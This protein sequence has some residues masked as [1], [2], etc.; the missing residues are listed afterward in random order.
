GEEL[1]SPRNVRFDAE[2]AHHLLRW[3][4]AHSA[5]GDVRYEVELKVYGTN[6]SWTPIPNCMKIWGHSCDLTFYTLAPALR[7][8]AR[9]RAVSGNHMSPWKKTSSFSP[10]EASLRLSGQSLSV[11]GNTIHVQLQLLLRAGNLTVR[12]DDVQ[13]HARRYRVY[14]RRMPDNWTFQVMETATE[15]NISN[16]FWATEYC[17]SVE[18]DVASRHIRSTRTAEQCVAT[19][20]R[21]RSAELVLNIISSFFITLVILGLLGALLVCAYVKQPMR[22]PSVL[23]SFIK[24]SSLWVEHESPSSGSPDTDPVQQLFLGQKE[25]QQGSGPD[26]NTSTAQLPLEQCWRLPAWP[27]DRVCPLGPGI[28]GSR[29]SSCTST[30]SGICLHVSSSGLSCSAGPQPQGYRQQLPTS[31]DSGVGLESACPHPTCSS[32]SGNASQDSQDSQQGVEF[33]GYLRQCKGTVEPRQDPDKGGTCAG[34]PRG[35]GSTDIVLDV[36]CPELAVA[37]GY[38]KQSSPEH[39]RSHAQD[40][41]PW[42]APWEPTTWD[43][44]SQVG[45]RDPPLLSYGAPRA[46]LASKAGP[47]LLKAP[48]D[49]SIFNTDLLGTLPLISSLSTN[50]WLMLQVNPLSL[51]SGDSKDSRL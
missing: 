23:K 20:E 18:P 51:L 30:D 4:P 35:P 19:G 40:L 13:K 24:Q 50:E 3:E 38:L 34:P 14:V 8:Y 49:L 36:E 17:V 48:F 41:A 21:D 11:T 16:L 28:T 10:R 44:S 31:D 5:P 37:K 45:A 7:Y 27:E 32:S 39:P 33:R 2:I 47:E 22:P 6:L 46:P 9:V 43:F 12:Y 29:D 26:A 1:A 25:P 42:S 15:F